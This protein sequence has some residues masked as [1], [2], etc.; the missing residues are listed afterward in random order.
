MKLLISILTLVSFEL[1]AFTNLDS[2]FHHN[3][4]IGSHTSYFSKEIRQPFTAN[5]ALYVCGPRSGIGIGYGYFGKI[6][7]RKSWGVSA[8]ISH[9]ICSYRYTNLSIQPYQFDGKITFDIVSISPE[10][11]FYIFQ[12]VNLRFGLPIN[13]LVSDKFEDTEIAKRILWYGDNGKSNFKRLYLSYIIDV[14]FNIHKRFGLSISIMNGLTSVGTLKTTEYG[15][16]YTFNEKLV[17]GYI[18]LNYRLQ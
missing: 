12:W 18:T 16:E 7:E 2:L 13:Y 1:K 8:F 9:S 6:T 17:S 10:Y 14:D 11:K 5:Q 4:S 15:K 3:L